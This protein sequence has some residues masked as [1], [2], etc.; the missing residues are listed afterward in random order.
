MQD[1]R[2]SMDDNYQTDKAQTVGWNIG[3]YLFH[4]L[5]SRV[6]NKNSLD[7]G[8]SFL[9]K[10]WNKPHHAVARHTT[11]VQRRLW[12][13]QARGPRAPAAGVWQSALH[14]RQHACV[15]RGRVRHRQ[16]CQKA[17]IPLLCGPWR[18]VRTGGCFFSYWHEV[19]C[20]LFVPWRAVQ[21][22]G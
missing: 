19:V 3:T 12:G 20:Q 2:A 4:C 16:Q 22:G 14:V 21:A 9:L 1:M 10:L 15:C 13:G 7:C 11:Q 18:A 6:A 8:S 17:D 5:I